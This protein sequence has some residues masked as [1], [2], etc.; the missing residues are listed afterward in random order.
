MCARRIF[1]CKELDIVIFNRVP[2]ATMLFTGNIHDG[3]TDN[4]IIIFG[5]H[6]HRSNSETGYGF[7]AI[8]NARL[9]V[10]WRRLSCIGC[11]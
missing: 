9:P 10:R 3:M 7:A 6:R 4:P 11:R 1:E 2:A 8:R 5:C